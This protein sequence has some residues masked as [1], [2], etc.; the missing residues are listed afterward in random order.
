[1]DNE[2]NTCG[3]E[4]AI[5]GITCDARNCAYNAEGCKCHAPEISVGPSYAA[6]SSETVCATFKPKSE[7]C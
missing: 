6:T 5:K 2:K 1:M 7:T 4:K 3:C